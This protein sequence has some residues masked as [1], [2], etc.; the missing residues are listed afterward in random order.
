M[1]LKARQA[2]TLAL[3]VNYYYHHY[4]SYYWDDINSL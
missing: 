4:Y 2:H 1:C 3:Y